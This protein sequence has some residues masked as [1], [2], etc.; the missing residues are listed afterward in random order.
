[1]ILQLSHCKINPRGKAAR[2]WPS[3]SILLLRSI[4]IIHCDPSESPQ[5]D[6][7]PVIRKTGSTRILSRHCLLSH[8]FFVDK[9]HGSVIQLQ[10]RSTVSRIILSRVIHT[11]S[12][13]QRMMRHP[14]F[15]SPATAV[16]AAGMSMFMSFVAAAL[17][18]RVEIKFACQQFFHRSIRNA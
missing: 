13:Q 2:L 6:G 14:D 15:E 3:G 5:A 12:M 9:I 4:V 10:I 1:M 16:T 11:G 7:M 17:C 8:H 18:F